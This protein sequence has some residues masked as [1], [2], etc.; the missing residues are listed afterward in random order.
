MIRAYSEYIGHCC[1]VGLVSVPVA[2]KDPEVLCGY[3][4]YV[5]VISLLKKKK[6]VSH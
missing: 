6:R 2:G 5:L 4:D 1:N 3:S